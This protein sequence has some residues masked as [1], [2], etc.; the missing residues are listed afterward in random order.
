MKYEIW[1][2]EQGG[3]YVGFVRGGYKFQQ[4]VIAE[5]I[6]GQIEQTRTVVE[7]S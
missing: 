5:A 7:S 3:I 1:Q 4:K 2:L 6:F